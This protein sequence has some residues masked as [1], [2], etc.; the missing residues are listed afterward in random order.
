MSYFKR[1]VKRR[2]ASL[3][4]KEWLEVVERGKL[5]RPDMRSVGDQ[6]YPPPDVYDLVHQVELSRLRWRLEMLM[7][8]MLR[9]E[10]PANGAG[11]SSAAVRPGQLLSPFSELWEF[12]VKPFYGDGTAR[13]T[14]TLSLKCSSNGLQATLTDPTSG[15][16]CCL[17]SDNPDDALLAL[18]VGLKEGSL[19]WRSSGFAKAKK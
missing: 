9:P 6:D 18:E 5:P 2:P 17:T 10:K 13:M 7:C 19:P 4:D 14:G 15:T 11:S 1:V 16:Y 12:L 3:T 8:A